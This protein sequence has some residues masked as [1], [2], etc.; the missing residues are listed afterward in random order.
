MRRHVTLSSAQ[1]RMW[2]FEQLEPGGTVHNAPAAFRFH[3]ELDVEA[4]T[5]ALRRVWERHEVLR[6]RVVDAQGEP[7]V[8]VSDS[9]PGLRVSDLRNLPAPGRDAACRA[10]LADEAER[11]FDLSAGPLVRCLLVQLADDHHVLVVNMHHIVTDGWSW[12]I[13]QRETAAFYRQL[14]HGDP[15]GL[16]SPPLQYV[17]YAAWQQEALHGGAFERDVVYWREA[18][19][20]SPVALDLPLDRPRPARPSFHCDVVTAVVPPD[21]TQR[22]IDVGRRCGATPFMIFLAAWTATLA[23]YSGQDDILVGVPYAGRSG[24]EFEHVVGVFVNTMVIRSQLIGDPSFAELLTRVR[25]AALD[26]YSHADLPFDVLVDELS[27]ARSQNRNPVFQAFFAYHLADEDVLDL[28]GVRGEALTVRAATTVFDVDLGVQARP[29]GGVDVT[30]AYATD[31]F[32]PATARRM[33]AHLLRIL[34]GAPAEPDRPLNDLPWPDRA[35]LLRAR[36]PMP[37]PSVDCLH[38]FVA[39]GVAQHP[40][41]IAVVHAGTRLT[42][43]EL[44]DSINKLAWHL[45]ERGVKPETPVG[46]CVGREPRLLVAI[47]ATLRAGGAYVPLDPGLPDERLRFMLADSAVPIAVTDARHGER[48][49]DHAATVV[50]LDAEAAEIARRPTTAP[51]RVAGPDNMA[52]VMYTSGSTG[53]PKGVVV[54]HRSAVG[55]VDYYRTRLRAEELDGVLASTPAGFDA[56]ILE[57]FA[58]PSFG[59]TIILVDSLFD[60]HLLHDAESVTLIQGVPS[61]IDELLRTAPL[62][63]GLTTIML[64]GEPLSGALVDRLFSTGT[65]RR[66]YNIYGVTEY[67]ADATWNLLEPGNVSLGL[68]EPLPGVRCYVLD[69]QQRPV[70]EGARGELYLAG[71]GLSR[72]YLNRPELT[73]ERFLPDPFHPDPG[74]RMYRTGDLVRRRPQGDLEY[75]GRLDS[76]VKVHGCRVELTEVEA[77]LRDHPSVG[78]AAVVAHRTPRGDNELAGYVVP[79][80]GKAMPEDLRRYL[81]RRLPAYMLPATFTP[82]PALPLNPNGKLD[83]GAL[84]DPEPGS[85]DRAAP[86]PPRTSAEERLAAIW[87]R[88]LDRSYIG[89]HDDFFALGGQSLLALRLLAMIR[90]E[91]GVDLPASTLFL[92]PT[93]A[94]IAD[95]LAT[96]S[97]APAPWVQLRPGGNRTPLVLLPAVGGSALSYV[98]LARA[99][100]ADR[101]VLGFESPGLDGR[102][103]PLLTVPDLA[104]HFLDQLDAGGLDGPVILGGW[105]MGGAVAYEMARQAPTR[106]RAVRALLLVDTSVTPVGSPDDGPELVAL[107]S[108]YLLAAVPADPAAREGA[109]G[110]LPPSVAADPAA[111]GPVPA[112]LNW[113]RGHRVVGAEMTAEQLG[114]MVQ[115]FGANMR[116]L[117][118][119]VPAP[120][121][122]PALYLA[123]SATREEDRSAPLRTAM[124]AHL[125]V[126]AAPGDHYTMLR[127]PQVGTVAGRIATWLDGMD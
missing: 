98:D 123:A 24:P 118:R 97:G 2:F 50:S 45:R 31:L 53:R 49:A 26:A 71:P 8:L 20:G 74:Q 39:Q 73:R 44:D 77:V 85:G 68:G 6:S 66:I 121:D 29:D 95:V 7:V 119:Y 96:G 46:V 110:P 79:E 17:D 11:P 111:R 60:L 5:E 13:I 93:I 88:V 41:R 30:L 126:E 69:Q 9:L 35:A 113:A 43:R 83:L 37:A 107:Y 34:E 127:P 67:T 65:V 27:T 114:R 63:A 47:Y 54:E 78:Q 38:D 25:A 103:A 87:R 102:S 94:E 81:A 82:L 55:L 42:Y 115:V 105:S 51:P 1:R 33:I 106:S 84:P 92:T 12:G 108:E 14:R 3:G 15:T 21:R 100:P 70:P 4:L 116:A 109:R 86:V 57:Y 122:V 22:L 52:Y 59:G 91:Y 58:T 40:D 124:G 19:S 28:D 75:L 18:L 56:S 112:L 10:L 61:V 23:H 62:P 101:P 89:V 16:P 125:Q 76:Q 48:L 72:G 104:A 32:D 36:H 80:P 117:D 90:Q 99:L 64:S 120:L